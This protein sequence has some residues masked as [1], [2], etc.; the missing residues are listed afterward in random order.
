MQ[1]GEIENALK[2]LEGWPGVVGCMGGEPTIHPDF[3]EICRLY[4]RYFPRDKCGLWTSGGPAFEKHRDLIARTFR[5]LL[6]N[7]HSEVGKHQPW[8]IA[9]D[10]VIDDMVLK[11]KLIDECWIQKLWSP[12]INPNGAFFCEIAAVFDLLFGLGGG[13]QIERG[14]WR[15]DVQ[16]FMDQRSL[17]CGLCSMAIP[18]GDIPNDSH[19]ECVSSGNAQWLRQINSPWADRLQVVDEKLTLDD[20]KG[21]LKDY[22]PWEYLGK[23]GVRDSKGRSRGGY[24]KK[25]HHTPL[26]L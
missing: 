19:L 17:Y 26:S 10:E 15:R 1:L 20:I 3:E 18:Y 7:D 6:Y 24:A 5:V 4:Q 11:E 13:Y 25:R 2:S 16:D 9:I 23:N 14:W 12:A 21:N 8:M 22:A